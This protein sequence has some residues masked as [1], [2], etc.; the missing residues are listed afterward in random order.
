M[1][2]LEKLA[3]RKAVELSLIIAEHVKMIGIAGAAL[4][5]TR[6]RD[7]G[8]L[9]QELGQ[10]GGVLLAAAGLLF[11]PRQLLEQEGGLKLGHAEVGAVAHVGEAGGRSAPSVVLKALALLDQFVAVREDRAAF[12]GIEVLGPLKAEAA[13]IAERAH[14]A[15][16][17]L[18]QVRLA[19]VFEH[20]DLVPG[21]NGCDRSRSA[22]AP[23][24]CTG[25]I[26][27][28][29][30]VMAASILRASIWKVSG[31]VSTKTGSAWCMSTALTVATKVYG[32]TITSSPG[33]TPSAASDVMSA[34]VPF[35]TARQC[36]A[37]RVFAQAC[38]N[39]LA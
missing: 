3:A 7:A 1:E 26:Q 8:N 30:S 4:V 24:K 21:G 6:R 36:L 37:P 19:G 32:G 39:S 5:H 27:R 15:A 17:P 38:S 35:A 10:V 11:E 29:F 34:L 33:P 23:P 14:F 16:A 9:A 31:S 20:G 2:R 12:A 28:V 13:Q 22:A 18:S 25:M